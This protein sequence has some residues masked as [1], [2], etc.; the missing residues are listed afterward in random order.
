MKTMS[1]MD[2]IVMVIAVAII[3]GVMFVNVCA[4]SDVEYSILDNHLEAID[5]TNDELLKVVTDYNE[6]YTGYFNELVTLDG[7]G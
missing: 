1:K 3:I 2:S 7:N 5:V 4:D 6:A